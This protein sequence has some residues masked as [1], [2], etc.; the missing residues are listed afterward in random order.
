MRLYLL[1][2]ITLFISTAVS[3]EVN[4]Y[5]ARKEA[6][7]KPLLQRFTEAT[8]T[9][10][11][12]VTGDAD[13]LIK[14]LE[15][16]GKNSPAD[17][18]L[19]VDAARLY[20][21]KTRGLF[22]KIPSEMVS[23]RVPARYRDEDG[24][25]TGLSLRARV[26]AYAADRVSPDQLT[27]YEDLADPKWRGRI[28][29]RSSSN[30]YNQSLVAGLV[31]HLGIEKTGTWAKGLVEN[32]ARAPRGGD[33]DQIKAVAAGQCDLA[34]VNT[35]YI[36]GMLTS[37][38]EAE[39]EAAA[40]VGVFW[41]NQQG[42]GAHINISGIGIT[43]AS[44]NTDQA[45]RLIEFLL[46]DEAQHWYAE[47]NFEYPVVA[48]IRPGETLQQWGDFKADE[49]PMNRLGEFNSEALR[50]MDRAGWK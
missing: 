49:L 4:I 34:L 10:V 17:V 44:K 41:P 12:L 37:S 40:K 23:A 18:L 35:Y 38:I 28:C 14:R 46:S 6:L 20:R 48:G 45:K 3:A 36:G 50:I 19:T 42:R 29:V 25:W 47:T 43:A 8:G 2:S 27:T 39:R 21:A 22:Q 24:Y 32:F 30:I 33:R 26:I 7:I 9:R 16:E 5:S 13:A 15:I 31:T 1:L 11:N